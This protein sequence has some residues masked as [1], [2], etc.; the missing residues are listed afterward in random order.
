MSYPFS[1]LTSEENDLLRSAIANITVLIAGADGKID[2]DETAW[3]AKIAKIRTYNSVDE[4]LPYYRAVGDGYEA[5]VDQLI[6][7]LPMD[8]EERMK[9]LSSR[10]E[11]LNDIL[12]KLDTKVA[13]LYYRDFVSFAHH[14]AKA[15]GGFLGFFQIG[16]NE[17]R[18]MDL[19]MITPVH[20]HGEE[21]E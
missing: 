16:P 7:E 20:Y 1:H 3:A 8:T 2:I 17:T 14:V 15:S 6:R 11:G 9:I 5:E 21:E 10:L 13:S 19:P 18:W 12:A 4:L